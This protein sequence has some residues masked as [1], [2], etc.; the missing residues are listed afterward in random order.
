VT[1]RELL[2]AVAVSTLPLEVLATIATG[3]ILCMVVTPAAAVV[4]A[5]IVGG[6]RS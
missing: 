2:P 4:A 3:S 1:R 6:Q 5:A